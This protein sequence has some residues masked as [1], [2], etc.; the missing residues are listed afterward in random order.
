MTAMESSGTAKTA[1]PRNQDGVGRSSASPRRDEDST[2]EEKPDSPVEK[3]SLNSDAGAEAVTTNLDLPKGATA[4]VLNS[5]RERLRQLEEQN[6]A[7]TRCL[8]CMVGVSRDALL[9]AEKMLADSECSRDSRSRMRQQ[10]YLGTHALGYPSFAR[11]VAMY[12]E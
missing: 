8:I 2:S 4:H 9:L 6:S 10:A 3:P 1:S 5:L 11:N 12:R 7:A